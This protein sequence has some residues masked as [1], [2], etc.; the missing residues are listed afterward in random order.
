[1]S[2]KF[3]KNRW[4]LVI[5]WYICIFNLEASSKRSLVLPFVENP[6]SWVWYLTNFC[7]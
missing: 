4:T 7:Y 1:M 2:G 6:V 5:N 3:L